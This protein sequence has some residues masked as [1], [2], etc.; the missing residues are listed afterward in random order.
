MAERRKHIDWEAVA[1]H[2]R[3]GT[4][5]LRDIGDEFGVSEGA[6]RKRAKKECWPR[7]LSEKIKAKAKEKVRIASVR[8]GTHGANETAQ[9]EAESDTQSRIVLSHRKDIPLKR[10]L[11]AKLFAEIE[12]MTDGADL[13]KT[14]QEA[15]A[16]DDA[17]GMA[18]AV[19]KVASLPQRIKGTTDLMNAY[20]TLIALERQ[21]FG[22]DDGSG[23]GEGGIEDLLKQIY[24]RSRPLVDND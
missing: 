6:I 16:S 14:L 13:F 10:E 18:K 23:M 7:D 22:I 17:E 4:R 15:L 9:V 21:A 24:Q 12:G 20:K 11:V 8:A 3:T 1:L 5:S 2:Y 19:C